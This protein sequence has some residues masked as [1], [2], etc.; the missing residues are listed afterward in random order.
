MHH[1][2]SPCLGG[3]HASDG[4]P[5]A[6]TELVAAETRDE[7]PSAREVSGRCSWQQRLQICLKGVRIFKS[8]DLRRSMP[9]RS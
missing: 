7:L 3:R 2:E 9:W 8:D 6:H 5:L 1:L 4:T